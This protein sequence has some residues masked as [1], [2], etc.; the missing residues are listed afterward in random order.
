MPS[1]K[2]KSKRRSSQVT[3]NLTQK[4]R[5]RV[6]KSRL[7]KP[8]LI[9]KPPKVKL[10]K[11]PE[12]STRDVRK[13][14]NYLR[15]IGL[16]KSRS[17]ARK[18]S[19]KRATKRVAQFRD[20]FS[21]KVQAIRLTPDAAKAYKRAG[22]RVVGNVVLLKKKPGEKIKRKGRKIYRFQRV[23]GGTITTILIPHSYH[24]LVNNLNI[25]KNDPEIVRLLEKGY[26][27]GFRIGN[28]DI[29]YN[30]SKKYL[31]LNGKGVK[32]VFNEM[33]QYIANGESVDMRVASG[34]LEL[35]MVNPSFKRPPSQV[36]R[37]ITRQYAIDKTGRTIE[38]PRKVHRYSRQEYEQRKN[39][40]WYEKNR[41]ATLLR[42]HRK[43]R[44]KLR[45][46]R[47]RK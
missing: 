28:P 29:G 35:L 45:K 8:A 9:F 23:K 16:F 1:R 39:S 43:M 47:Q 11:I 41:K 21:G 2:N 3:K 46:K 20:I 25:L 37:A 36:N 24:D 30:Y 40:P 27:L 12:A 10:T 42:Y 14:W 18:I 34:A 26:K 15:K 17:D 5:K 7:I 31:P 33:R 22:E 6:R 4:G 32:G 38:R 44:A 13:A 19:R